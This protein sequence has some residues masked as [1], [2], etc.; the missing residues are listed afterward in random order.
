MRERAKAEQRRQYSHHQGNAG[1]SR[2]IPPGHAG[3]ET[4]CGGLAGHGFFHHLQN[5]RNGR[6]SK[7]CG[8]FHPQGGV[9]VDCSG[10]HP[11][12]WGNALRH[13]FAREG[14][15]V[16]LRIA[17]KH[18]SVQRNLFAGAHKNVTAGA[19]NIRL[20]IAGTSVWQHLVGNAGAGGKQCLDGTARTASGAFLYKFAHTIKEHD[21]HSLWQLT[22]SNGRYGCAA[23]QSEFVEKITFQDAF[24]ADTQYFVTTQYIWQC[25]EYGYDQPCGHVGG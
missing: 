5:A 2:C 4:L 21:A 12:A 15:G 24:E 18:R 19:K 11:A 13:R 14:R 9:E 10:Q 25:V 1:N 6:F 7:S 3:D 20:H 22:K 16:H 17:F 23:H 8:N